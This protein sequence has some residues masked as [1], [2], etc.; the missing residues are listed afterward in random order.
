M[1]ALLASLPMFAGEAKTLLAAKEPL[2][3]AA[4]A[5]VAAEAT[6]ARAQQRAEEATVAQIVAQ[7]AHDKA[8][9]AVAAKANIKQV[10]DGYTADGKR[11]VFAVDDAL[12]SDL[13][14]FDETQQAELRAFEAEIKQR[15]DQVAAMQA[16]V[17]AQYDKVR[18]LRNSPP[19]RQRAKEDGLKAALAKARSDSVAKAK[20]KGS[21]SAS[22]AGSDSKLFF[23]NISEWGPTAK[24]F[25]R[26]QAPSY[27]LVA[28]CETHVLGEQLAT[29][30][31]DL[32]K[33]GWKVTATPAVLTGRSDAGNTGGEWVVSRKSVC[34]TSFESWR[35]AE[36]QRTGK[37]CFRGFAPLLWHTRVGNIVVVSCY[38]LPGH[39]FKGPNEQML[40]RLA[41]F[42]K[43][44]KDPWILVGD[45]NAVPSDWSKTAWISKLGGNICVPINGQ[46]TCNKGR[47]SLID[48]A[49]VKEG[50]ADSIRVHIVPEVPWRTHAGICVTLKAGKKAWWHRSLRAAQPLPA[51]PRPVRAADPNS[52]RQKAIAQAK[53][54]RRQELDDY[55]QEAYA[56]L[57][58]HDEAP[59]APA[60]GPAFNIPLEC[61]QAAK[62]K[63]YEGTPAHRPHF[64]LDRDPEVRDDVGLRYGRWVQAVEEATIAHHELPAGDAKKCRGRA[65]GYDIEWKITRA[66]PSRPHLRDPLLEWWNLCTSLLSRLGIFRRT[67]R[68][69]D[70]AYTMTKLL[71]LLDVGL[72][73]DFQKPFGDDD[74]FWTWVAAIQQ[75]GTADDEE[76]DTI[77]QQA[78][79][80]KSRA[81]GLSLSKARKG[82]QAWATKMWKESPGILHRHVKGVPDKPDEIIADSKVFA[83]PD[84]MMDKRADDWNEIWSDDT[85]V[86]AKIID[87][88]Q[89][90]MGR[91]DTQDLEQLTAERMNSALGSMNGKK[92]KGVDA[93]GPIEVQ[94]LP[95]EAR[96]ELLELVKHIERVAMWPHQLF[97]VIAAVAPK[98]KGGDRILGLLP[99]LPKLWSKMR[100]ADSLD[101]TVAMDEHWDTAIRGSSA[102]Q[103]AL[104]RSLLD[105]TCQEMKISC[106]TLL[107]DLEKLYDS[108]SIAKMCAAG[109]RQGFPALILA[110]ELQLFLAP[111]HLKDR[112]WLSKAIQPEKSLMAGSLQSGRFAKAFMGPM[113]DRAHI[114]YGLRILL[115]TFVDDTVVRAE[116]TAHEV[117]SLMIDSCTSLA[118]DF[119]DA[120]L[121]I[122]PKTVVVASSSSLAA[123]ITA[124]LIDVGIPVTPVRHAVDLGADTTPGRSRTRTKARERFMKAK[125][126]TSAI[127]RMRRHA[128]LRG[129]T[130]GL[131]SMGSKPQGTYTHQTFGI[132]GY[133]LVQI[134]RQAA[135]SA[136]GTGPGRCLTTSLAAA[137]DRRDPAKALRR[138]QV[139]AWLR[140]W[141]EYPEY[142]TRIARSWDS[143]RSRLRLAGS[144][145][146][147]VSKGPIAATIST[148]LD[149]GWDPVSPMVWSSDEQF[150]WHIPSVASPEF[151]NFHGDFTDIL[152][153]I[154]ATIDRQLWRAAALHEAAS[155]LSEGADMYHVSRE[156]SRLKPDLEGDN[157]A[158]DV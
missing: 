99:F 98:P 88:L 56:D 112:L 118:S 115:R 12:F 134:R 93:M 133:E 18:A 37:D 140:L 158:L 20:G 143:I 102:L 151:D 125:K 144:R 117:G 28:F 44:I 6:L 34:T 92:A 136:V 59:P 157:W 129:I 19:K 91:A 33:D 81:I 3:S 5:V 107:L 41:S 68:V 62:D 123:R 84:E 82:F 4:E 54:R 138:E 42:L 89:Y 15:I 130:K 17:H 11:V 45:W 9:A 121:K 74:Q 105:E 35:Q 53:Q 25:M 95:A 108:I 24:G 73:S 85:M 131:W 60:A 146:W 36:L 127:M 75:I 67:A 32:G 50:L 142:H 109:I 96:Q 128:S 47:G 79:S 30:K 64:L 137:F 132:P 153:D 86:P 29:A 100:S 122:S 139:L 46:V 40:I 124:G 76:F 14:E 156:L 94:R 31:S 51:L 78:E 110:L 43:Q 114:N 152:D 71:E 135:Q 26:G 38:L 52:K 155:D 23:A 57:Y 48:Y 27:D 119:V 2:K 104:V 116:G 148:L 120:G 1:L 22:S 111:R 83:T 106:A 150:E 147:R 58:D 55:L 149:I 141:R 145:R 21:A 90:V 87:G 49:I 65:Q 39:K 154:E 97:M 13:S 77:L 7:Q 113:P 8:V 103:A 101:W 16:E 70:N 66:T 72:D 10:P 61:W 80:Y 63:P 69:H 126:R